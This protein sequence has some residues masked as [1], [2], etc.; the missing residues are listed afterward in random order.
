M[1][2]QGAVALVTGSNQGIGRGLVEVLLERGAAKVYATA[3][4]P[5]TLDAIC[6]L[7]PARV[8]PL[9]LD[10][11]IESDRRAAAAAAADV[12]LLINN[13]GIPGDDESAQRRFVAA[14]TLDDARHVMETDFWATAE[15]CR[16]FIPTLLK[17]RG[18]NRWSGSNRQHP[19]HRRA[20]L[21]AGVCDLL[22]RQIR[23]RR[24]DHRAAR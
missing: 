8:S 1:K 19:F 21:L 12:T 2:L 15:M 23:R 10:I 24:D 14:P 9:K 11:V 4:R 16:A 17:N 7:D 3:R 13:A 6:A 20:V 18:R 22:R 5:E